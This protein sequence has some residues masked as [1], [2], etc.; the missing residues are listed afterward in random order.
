LKGC[1]RV[2]KLFLDSVFDTSSF[3]G[4]NPIRSCWLESV[5]KK[6]DVNIPLK[7]VQIFLVQL[8]PK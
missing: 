3:T 5:P 7:N 8:I 4:M 2:G 6:L 1:F